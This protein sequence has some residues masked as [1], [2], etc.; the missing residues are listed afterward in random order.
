MPKIE[1]AEI[2]VRE[3]EAVATVHIEFGEKEPQ[4]EGIFNVSL[5]VAV[6]GAAGLTVMQIKERAMAT[7]KR[8]RWPD[9]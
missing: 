2:N 1:I 7:A 4:F 5:H 9:A 6:P 8:F 3:D